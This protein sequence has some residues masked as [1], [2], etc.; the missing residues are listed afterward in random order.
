MVAMTYK[1]PQLGNWWA[2]LFSVFAL[3][4]LA[5]CGAGAGV[6]QNGSG[7]SLT[8]SPAAGFENMRTGSEEDFM[9]N[10][11]RRT[12]FVENS[13]ELDST[14]LVTLDKQANWLLANPG[15]LVKV[16]GF[17]DDPG[18][19]ADNKSL[20]SRRAEE[21]MNY[22]VSRGVPANRM[23]AKG[24]GRDR[25]IRDCN[26]IVCKSQNRRVISNLRDQFDS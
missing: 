17:A 6:Q 3:L 5:G 9:L 23:W 15:W 13:A 19:E 25:L 22:L 4:A 16:Q 14:A 11:G 24:Y 18:S 12:Y 20:S 8:N 10:V 7:L 1:R 2:R 21:V 26:D